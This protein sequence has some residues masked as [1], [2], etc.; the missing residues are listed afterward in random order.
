MTH[1][2][3]ESCNLNQNWYGC[4]LQ[5]PNLSPLLLRE[6][7]LWIKNLKIISKSEMLDY[8]N[9]VQQESLAQAKNHLSDSM[10]IL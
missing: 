8:L 3:R 5:A 1:C 10:G 4:D 7:N 9:V 6:K 2:P